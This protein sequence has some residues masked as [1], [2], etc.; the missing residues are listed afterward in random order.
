M[1]FVLTLRLPRDSASRLGFFTAFSPITSARPRRPHRSSERLRARAV[2]RRPPETVGHRRSTASASKSKNLFPALVLGGG[3]E[4]LTGKT[5]LRAAILSA[6]LFF[7]STVFAFNAIRMQNRFGTRPCGHQP[8][9]VDGVEVLIS[10]QARTTSPR[11]RAGRTRTRA[12]TPWLPSCSSS[13]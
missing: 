3:E 13:W 2:V 4:A 1:L 5:K 9:C 8:R 10:S 11:R 6:T 12:R 7:F